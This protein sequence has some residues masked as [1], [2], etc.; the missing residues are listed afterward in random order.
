MLVFGVPQSLVS[1]YIFERVYPMKM[2]RGIHY[3][4]D[5]APQPTIGGPVKKGW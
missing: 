4:I 2:L 3:Q 1:K 5:T